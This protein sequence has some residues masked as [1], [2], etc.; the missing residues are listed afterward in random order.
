MARYAFLLLST[1]SLF[2]FVVLRSTLHG[3]IALGGH[4]AIPSHPLTLHLRSSLPDRRYQRLKRSRNDAEIIVQHTSHLDI[5][6]RI[7]DEDRK[8]KRQECSIVIQLLVSRQV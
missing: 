3:Q 1:L 8:R 5:V 4:I 7:D 6:A 2:L